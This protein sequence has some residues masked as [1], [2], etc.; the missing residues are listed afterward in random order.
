[1][2]GDCEAILGQET[3]FCVKSEGDYVFSMVGWPG[4]AVPTGRVA[5]RSTLGI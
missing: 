4:P 1:M 2:I 5:N 3:N